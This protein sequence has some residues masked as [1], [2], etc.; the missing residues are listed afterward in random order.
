MRFDKIWI[1]AKKDLAEFRTNKYVMYSILLMPLLLSIVLPVIYL[2]PF[3]SMVSNNQPLDVGNGP[4]WSV[5]DGTDPIQ[6]HL[7]NTTFRQC[8]LTDVIAINCRF[9]SV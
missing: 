4:T 6:R 2:A 1:V 7:H 5:I 3:S 8:D 9:E